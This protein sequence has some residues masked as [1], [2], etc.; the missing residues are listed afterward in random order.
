MTVWLKIG[1]GIKPL[2]EDHD[3]L[4]KID[5]GIKPLTGDRDY[6]AEVG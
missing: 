6:L 1:E 2:T 5:E 3:C 4:A